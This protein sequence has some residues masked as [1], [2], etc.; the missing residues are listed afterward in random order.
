MEEKKNKS[1]R[2]EMNEALKKE[3]DMFHERIMK[4]ANSAEVD[5]S[6]LGGMVKLQLSLVQQI[7]REERAL[8][9]ESPY[10]LPPHVLDH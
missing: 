6:V 5:C 2:I 3:F 1:I 10:L 7:V 4:I 9:G 8:S